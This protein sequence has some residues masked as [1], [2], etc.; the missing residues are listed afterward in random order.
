[1]TEIKLKLQTPSVPNFIRIDMSVSSTRQEGLKE[2]PTIDIA[3]L[4]REQLE[5]IANDWRVELFA[6]SMERKIKR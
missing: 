2:L 6:K 3:D 4:T 1:M 5:S